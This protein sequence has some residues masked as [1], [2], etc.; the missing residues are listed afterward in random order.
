[1]SDSDGLARQSLVPDLGFALSAGALLALNSGFLNGV[2]LL[3][4]FNLAV[5]HVTGSTTNLGTAIGGGNVGLAVETLIVIL[6]FFGGNVLSGFLVADE[7]LNRRHRRRYGLVLLVQTAFVLVAIG[8]FNQEVLLASYSLA[9]A[10]GLQNGMASRYSGATVRT[11]HVTGIVT[12]LGIALGQLLRRNPAKA[13]EMR[14]LATLLASFLAGGVVA[15][16]TFELWSFNTLWLSAIGT[17]VT[18]LAYSLRTLSSQRR[19][20]TR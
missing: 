4:L 16:V 3:S 2:A 14:L 12:D 20:V 15:G 1:M 19:G 17:G 6:S 9:F 18:G 10:C 13:W 5:S 11:S 8:L 7:E